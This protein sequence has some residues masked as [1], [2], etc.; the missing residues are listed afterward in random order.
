MVFGVEITWDA[1]ENFTTLIYFLDCEGEGC[2]VLVR[3]GQGKHTFTAE[4]PMC[5]C[6]FAQGF[7][8]YS[9]FHVGPVGRLHSVESVEVAL[10]S[11]M[12]EDLRDAR[13]ALVKSEKVAKDG[14][15]R[16]RTIDHAP[17][18]CQT[19]PWRSK[20]GSDWCRHPPHRRKL[21]CLYHD[22]ANG[23]FCRYRGTCDFDHIDTRTKHGNMGRS[24]V[25]PDPWFF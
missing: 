5:E 14:R 20:R 1:E 8:G 19:A 22:P 11:E 2:E 21:V 12:P 17:G 18:K 23:L 25:R 15:K 6:M 4:D 10:P 13:A 9:L 3:E 16:R 7:A 24:D